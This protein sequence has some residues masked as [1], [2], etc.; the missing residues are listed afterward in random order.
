MNECLLNGS[1]C[2]AG[3]KPADSDDSLKV[4]FIESNGKS[5]GSTGN[6]SIKVCCFG[7]GLV[8]FV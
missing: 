3:D 5:F 4:I 6:Y 1:I 7:Y 2:T 8:L